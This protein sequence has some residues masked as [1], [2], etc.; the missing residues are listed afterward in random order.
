MRRTGNWR[1]NHR[2]SNF[3]SSLFTLYSP[4]DRGA[5]WAAASQI[6]TRTQPPK[7]QVWHK[8]IDS[9]APRPPQWSPMHMDFTSYSLPGSPEYIYDLGSPYLG[10]CRR[11]LADWCISLFIGCTKTVLFS[12]LYSPDLINVIL[13]RA[14]E[15]ITLFSLKCCSFFWWN[16]DK[17]TIL[18]FLSILKFKA[19]PLMLHY[20]LLLMLFFLFIYLPFC[21]LAWIRIGSI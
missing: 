5:T 16:V 18:H 3:F 19:T 7:S 8:D 12:R 10:G 20:F 2:D 1:G 4:C 15:K 6:P 13:Y 17:T 21:F 14:T 9:E 11:V